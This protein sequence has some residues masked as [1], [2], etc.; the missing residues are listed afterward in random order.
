MNSIFLIV[1]QAD[2]VYHPL[3]QGGFLFWRQQMAVV[4]M[5]QDVVGLQVGRAH[6]RGCRQIGR[7]SRIA[8]WD[9]IHDV[10]D[11]VVIAQKVIDR[12]MNSC[13]Q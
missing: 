4:E 2:G 13:L 11:E 9:G 1:R 7:P 5:V 10:A 12:G 3:F 6:G 8:V